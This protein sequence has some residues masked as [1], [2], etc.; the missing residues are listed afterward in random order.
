PASPYWVRPRARPC[1]VSSDI[2]AAVRASRRGRS[3][4]PRE[5]TLRAVADATARRGDR[6]AVGADG[7]GGRVAS[8]RRRDGT[9]LLVVAEPTGHRVLD[10]VARL[11][12]VCIATD[13][14]DALRFALQQPLHLV[15]VGARVA[16]GAACLRLPVRR[17]RG[18]PQS[19]IHVERCGR[20]RG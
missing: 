17:D 10:A 20:G 15:D 14:V 12:E 11:R 4:L 5:R 7:A 9:L 16:L 2:E 3:R 18:L 1:G 8:I 6:D 13:T 19:F